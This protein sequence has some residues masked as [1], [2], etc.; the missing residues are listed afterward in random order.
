MASRLEI[1]RRALTALPGFLAGLMIFAVLWWITGEA[2]DWWSAHRGEVDAVFIRYLGTART[3]LVHE[4][5]FQTTWLVRWALGLAAVAGLVAAETMGGTRA[6]GR[7]LRVAVEIVPLLATIIAALVIGKGL[8]RLLYWRPAAIPANW[9][10]TAFVAA[11]LSVLY[12][13]TIVIAAMVLAAF[14]RAIS[15]HAFPARS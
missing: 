2:D 9:L 14:Q 5:V 15:R 1:G 8:S 13:M 7:G 11:K 6:A 12:V 4:G 3:G 10:Q